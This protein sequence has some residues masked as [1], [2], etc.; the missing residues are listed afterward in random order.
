MAPTAKAMTI[1]ASHPRKRSRRVTTR[2][3]MT[4]RRCAS[5]IITTMIG[6]AITPFITAAQNNSLMG[7]TPLKSSTTPTGAAMAPS[8]RRLG[9]EPTE[10]QQHRRQYQQIQ[11]RGSDEAAND[12]GGHRTFDFATRFAR[13]Q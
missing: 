1:V 10:M 12:D 13:P 4:S 6:T 3:P 5:S 7:S 11:H 9:L 2:G 8:R